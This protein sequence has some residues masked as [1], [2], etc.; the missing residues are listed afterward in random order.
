MRKLMMLGLATLIALVGLVA[1]VTIIGL[2]L[3][4]E[5]I[6]SRAMRLGQPPERVWQVITDYGSQPAWRR[7]LKGIERLPDREGRAVW[8]EI[9]KDGQRLTLEAAEAVPPRRLVTRIADVGGPFSGRWEFEIAPAG[10]GSQISIT[11]R[12][13]L[14]N[15]LFRFISR[16][17]IG[18]A[19]F[20]DL[21]LQ[22][23]AGKFGEPAF[24]T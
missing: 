14:P 15:P 13:Q 3:P 22:A 4:K 19:T 16:F 10:D 24:I 7:D 18:Q 5:H 21:Y 8:Q 11:E 20:I 23:L 6:A 17:I 2:C 12:G 9:Y 1:I